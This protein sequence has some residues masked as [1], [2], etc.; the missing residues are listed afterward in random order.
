MQVFGFSFH[1]YYKGLISGKG[2]YVY[3][4]AMLFLLPFSAKAQV[5]TSPAFPMETT[6]ISIFFDATKGDGGLAGYTGDVYAHTGVITD[7]SDPSNPGDWKYVKTDWGQN[8]VSTKLTRVGTDLYR[9]D[10]PGIR[11]YYGVPASDKILKLA[12]VFR[13]ADSQRE[14]KGDGSNDIFVGI[15]EAGVHVKFAEPA[16]PWNILALN[17][18]LDV[19]VV[20]T[21]SGGLSE[22][23]LEENGVEIASAQNDSLR[24]TLTASSAER[25]VLTAIAVANNGRRDT[26]Q[27]SYM[28]PAPTQSAARP[29][30]INQGIYYDDANPTKV[31]LSL[32]APYKNRV[33]VIGDFNDWEPMPEYQMKKHQVGGNE[34]YWWLEIDGLVPGEEYAFQYLVDEELRVAD[35]FSE[36]V[37]HPDDRWINEEIYPDLK[38]YPT[39]KTTEYVGVLQTNKPAFNWTDQD[40]VRPK[41]EDLIIYELLIRDFTEEQTY[42]SVIDKLDYLEALGINA[43]ELLPVNEFEGNNS[44]GYNPAFY[45]APDKAYGPAEDLKRLV[46]E[47]HNRGMAVILDAVFNHSFG[48]SPMVRLYNEGNYGKPTPQNIWFNVDAK[49]PFNVGYDFNHDSPFTQRFIDAVNAY[50]IEEYHIDG[51]RYD[52][53]KGFTQKFTSDVGA[54]NQYDQGRVDNLLRMKNELHNKHPDAYLIL[55]HLGDN[56]EEKVLADNGFMLWGIMHEQYK[57]ALLAHKDSD[58]AWASWKS[59]G[60]NAPHLVSYMESHDEE[61]QMLELKNHGKVFGNYSAKEKSAALNRLKLGHAFLLAI[62]GPKMIWQ[63][64]ELGYDLS[65]NRCENGSINSDCRTS[66]KPPLWEYADDGDRDRLFRTIGELA[67]LKTTEAAFKTNDFELDVWGKH[68]R[69]LLRSST[70]FQILGNF[71]VVNATVTPF[72]HNPGSG[73]WWYEYFTG[74]SLYFTNS[75]VPGVNLKPGE[76]RIYSTRKLPAPEAGLLNEKLPDINIQ[77]AHLVFDEFRRKDNSPPFQKNV[78]LTNSGSAPLII[79]D[80]TNFN[81]VFSIF[82]ENATL[83]PGE[84]ITLSVSFNPAGIGSWN[85]AF[86]IEA[87]SLNNTQITVS[88]AYR[89][90]LPGNVQL[91]SPA[92]NA[93]HQES[94]LFVIWQ[95]AD[96]ADFY[97][98]EVKDKAGDVFFSETEITAT[99]FEIDGLHPDAFYTWRVRAANEDGNGSW[100]EEYKFRTKAP[101]PAMVQLTAPDSAALSVS[102]SPVFTWQPV[103]FAQYYE[104]VVAEDEDFEQI[105]ASFSAVET[106]TLQVSGLNTNTGYFWKVRAKNPSGTGA[107]SAEWPFTTSSLGTPL[108]LYPADNATQMPLDATLKWSR[109]ENAL[110]Y[111]LEISKEADFKKTALFTDI[112]DTLFKPD[113]F[114]KNTQYFWRIKSVNTEENSGWSKVSAF[115][116][117]YDSPEVPAAHT[118]G[119]EDFVPDVFILSWNEAKLASYYQLQISETD[120]FNT[121]VFDTSGIQNLQL[122]INHK[123]EREKHYYWRIRAINPGHNSEWSPAHAF[124]TLPAVPSFPLA[125]APADSLIDTATSLTFK[126]TKS[127]DENTQYRFQLSANSSFQP[128]LDTTLTDTVF[129]ISGLA[130]NQTYYWRV[131]SQ[132]KGGESGWTKTRLFRTIIPLPGIST[133]VKPLT[134][135]VLDPENNEFVWTKSAG[136]VTHQIQISESEGFESSYLDSSLVTS[137]KLENIA[138]PEGA[139]LYW[140]VRGSNRAGYGEWSEAQ[141]ITV[142]LKTGIERK[143]L[144][145]EYA[146]AQNYPNPFNP[147]TTITYALPAPQHVSLEVYSITGQKVATIFEGPQT[148]GYHSVKF[149]ASHLAS[150]MYLYRINAGRFSSVKK[151]LLIK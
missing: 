90:T 44:W 130:H 45:F 14:G 101:V 131:Q 33:Y 75:S 57:E 17:D 121:V 62:P 82:P 133:V 66:P 111:H 94:A 138:L 149:D 22:L 103:P 43:I 84:K 99:Q 56:A 52:L 64:G 119:L 78:S 28:V 87:L 55:E 129:T 92:N 61:R 140:R 100:S 122:E 137:L 49:H 109:A 36:K 91:I 110:S 24:L 47:A 73:K 1:H 50:W 59:R 83:Q 54:W 120:D 88:A 32:L 60:W 144:P 117:I 102:N 68:K 115:Y 86:T 13:S 26:S 40:Y 48:Q 16:Q 142:N 79:T 81:P 80:I 23:I 93:Q 96:N 65:I 51:Y 7:K 11:S 35:P 9:L 116:S 147:V 58:I 19:L 27:V 112:A 67:K 150:G 95:P 72:N 18:K 97:E 125:L 42:A 98:L 15:Y 126:W 30:G 4:L 77:P 104:L 34:V 25:K 37:L 76:F 128:R 106:T 145:R 2:R 124:T 123:L 38:P 135:D 105:A 114:E 143:D 53:S 69:I 70:D 63:F 31:T 139:E 74:D 10:I 85:D 134:D 12:F 6:P 3:M 108:A 148:A 39:G 127:G 20:A 5:S 146:L 118:K 89:E 113:I 132:N 151:L 136:A 29:S 8:T 41:K 141:K 71:D 21:A 46:N 107:W